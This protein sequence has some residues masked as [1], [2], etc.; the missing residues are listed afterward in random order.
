M[1]GMT[2]GHPLLRDSDILRS[3]LLSSGLSSGRDRLKAKSITDLISFNQMIDDDMHRGSGSSSSMLNRSA[4]RE[5]DDN[6][7]YQDNHRNN[8]NNKIRKD[9]RYGPIDRYDNLSIGDLASF[10]DL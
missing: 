9:D 6:H 2:R 10:E 1:P 4:S 3:T 8:S 5:G 7:L